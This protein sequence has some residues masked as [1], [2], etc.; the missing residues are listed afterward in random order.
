[1]SIKTR[2]EEYNIYEHVQPGIMQDAILKEH[3]SRK[4]RNNPFCLNYFINEPATDLHLMWGTISDK[5]GNDEE[6]KRME[7]EVKKIKG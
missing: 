5:N 1:M 4:S 6:I 7:G 2:Q 3:R